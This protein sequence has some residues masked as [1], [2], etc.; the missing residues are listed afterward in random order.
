MEKPVINLL[1]STLAKL[2]VKAD[3]KPHPEYKENLVLS[4]LHLLI[5]IKDLSQHPDKRT[6]GAKNVIIILSYHFIVKNMCFG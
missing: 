5:I 4:P 2:L 3:F 6:F 1:Y